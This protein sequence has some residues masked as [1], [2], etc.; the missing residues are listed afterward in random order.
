MLRLN[1]TPRRGSRRTAKGIPWPHAPTRRHPQPPRG[2]CPIRLSLL[3]F[4]S[5]EHLSARA[6][7]NSIIPWMDPLH[8]GASR[9]FE[10][11]YLLMILLLLLPR[12]KLNHSKIHF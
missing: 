11:T 9:K 4:H 12:G 2:V 10:N 6:V 1:Q 5:W 7:L 3:S 8:T